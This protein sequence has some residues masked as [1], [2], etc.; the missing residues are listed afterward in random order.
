[1]STALL[2]HVSQNARHSRARPRDCDRV[3]VLLALHAESVLGHILKVAV[4]LGV[5]VR[6]QSARLLS[7]QQ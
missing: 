7:A 2:M 5:L 3:N 1:M 4:Q 6:A